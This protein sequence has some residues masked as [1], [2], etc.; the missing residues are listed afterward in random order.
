M[1]GKNYQKSGERERKVANLGE[2]KKK[3]LKMVSFIT[4]KLSGF[5]FPERGVGSL[6]AKKLCGIK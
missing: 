3:K 4:K 5:H 6:Q 2:K 1:K